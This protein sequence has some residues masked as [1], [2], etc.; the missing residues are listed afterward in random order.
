MK[1]ES[2]LFL[3]ATAVAGATFAEQIIFEDDFSTYTGGTVNGADWRPKW[4]DSVTPAQT[5]LLTSDGTYAVLDNSRA[6]R[7][8]HAPTTHGFTL[9][10]DDNMIIKADMRFVHAPGGAPETP[11]QSFFSL[12]LSTS[13]NWWEGSHVNKALVMRNAAIGFKHD[14]T[15]EVWVEGWVPV[16][17]LGVD[18]T[19]GGTSDWFSVQSSLIV[20]NGTIWIDTDIYGEGGNGLIADGTPMDTGLAEGTMVYAGVT[21]GFNED[22]SNTVEAVTQVSEV[23]FDNFYVGTPPLETV[24][25][26]EDFDDLADYA[27]VQTLPEWDVNGNNDKWVGYNGYAMQRPNFSEEKTGTG[28]GA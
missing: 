14:G 7:N 28:W 21:T 5:D 11:N 15:A 9:E 27:S 8:Y 22:P 23:H 2:A 24:I 6:L 3:L 16:S 12:N 17:D 4:D 20:S 26:A 25:W 1:K 19:A 13:T 10:G 18:A